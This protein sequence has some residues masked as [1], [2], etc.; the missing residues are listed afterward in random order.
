MEGDGSMKKFIFKYTDPQGITYPELRFVRD[1]NPSMSQYETPSGVF[2]VLYRSKCT[3]NQSGL[4]MMARM[5][6][7]A[8]LRQ[9]REAATPFSDVQAFHEKFKMRYD[10]P[11]RTLDKELQ[12]FRERFD[13]EEFA[14]LR[15]ARELKDTKNELDAIVDLCYTMLGYCYLR[16]WDFDT[17]WGRV[18]AKNMQKRRAETAAESK[19]GYIGDIV[20]PEGWTPADL[21]DLV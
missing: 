16:G 7:A 8:V 12:A 1:I 6:E 19:R 20:K 4:D 2:K 5:G 10:G 3:L 9:S 21:S 13:A 17:A 15:I 11:P 14:E 18:H